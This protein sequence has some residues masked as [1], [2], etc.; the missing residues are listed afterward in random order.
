MKPAS[1]C[2]MLFNDV[3]DLG[4]GVAA[5][6]QLLRFSHEEAYPDV[7]DG[8]GAALHHLGRSMCEINAKFLDGTY[9]HIRA[10]EEGREQGAMAH[11]TPPND[12][13][14]I[15]E[16]RHL[17]DAVSNATDINQTRPTRTALRLVSVQK[18]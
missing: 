18:P 7:L 13:A 2:E 16:L 8:I 11:S 15:A 6:G 3:R 1:Q 17:L 10:M 9:Q 4:S 12:E 14:T 5:I